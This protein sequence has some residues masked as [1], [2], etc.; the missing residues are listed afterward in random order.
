MI[1]ITRLTAPLIVAGLALAATADADACT[2]VVYAGNNGNVA[3]G[4]TLDWRSPIPTSLYIM[5]R[6]IARESYDSGDRLQWTS[7]YGSVVSVGY[8]MGVS[9][10]LNEAGLSVN[11]LYLPGTIYKRAEET[12][13]KMSSTVWAQYILDNFATVDEAVEQLRKDEFYID[14]PEMP[15]GSA[16][17]T[18]MAISDSTGN[19]AIIEY[20][21]G[22]LSIHVGKEYNVLTNLPTY[23]SQLAVN[24]YWKEIGGTHMLPGTNRSSDRFVRASF[25]LNVLPPTLSHN[26]AL[27]GVFGIIRNCSVPMGISFPDSPEISTTQWRSVADQKD[28][29]YYL[30]M[31]LSPA[32]VWIDLH[33][34]DLRPGAPQRKLEIKISATDILAGDV[35]HKFK[36]TTPFKPFFHP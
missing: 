18:H 17:T 8:D 27:A 9:E 30:E 3:T 23:D 12:R 2:R 6:G 21:N 4:R 33:K 14:A 11:I 19:N 28:M 20:I 35:T 36:V 5:P 29:V 32:V 13:K 10:G 31:T 24:N 16:S 34:A 26:E 7:R 15:E 1:S 25:Y 22:E